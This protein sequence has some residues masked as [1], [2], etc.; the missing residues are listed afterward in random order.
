MVALFR[1]T[2]PLLVTHAQ[3]A[4]SVSIIMTHE[5]TSINDNCLSPFQ[6]RLFPLNNMVSPVAQQLR[7]VLR[8]FTWALDILGESAPHIVSQTTPSLSAHQN[9]LSSHSS[10]ECVH[11]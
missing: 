9:F 3:G 2:L 6:E 8:Q 5:K 11:I 10:S 7:A 1:P 4:R